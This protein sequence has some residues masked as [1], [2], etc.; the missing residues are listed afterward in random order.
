M[1]AFE[2][3]AIVIGAI[4]L[5]TV[6]LVIAVSNLITNT[7][8]GE[9]L[10][11]QEPAIITRFKLNIS[12][13][14]GD[15]EV[16]ERTD[17]AAKKLEEL[18][19]ERVEMIAR[20]GVRL[21]GHWYPCDNPVRIILAVHGWRSRWS[22]DYSGISPF[23]HENG[24]SVLYVEQRGQNA[25]D[26]DT[27]GF[28]MVER[29][30]CLDWLNWLNE[31]K[32]SDLPVYLAGISMGAASVLMAS[33]MGLPDNVH[34][35]MADCG[36]TSPKAIWEHI[37]KDNL[38]VSYKIREKKIDRMCKKKIGYT[39][40]EYST[41]KA[42]ET[43]STPILFVHGS[44]DT[45]VPIEMTY[46]N[47]L[48]CKAPKKLLVVPGANHAVSYIIDKDSYQKAVREFWEEFD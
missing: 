48:A 22:I 18:V 46:Q 34:G 9:A 24:C 25:S 41:L 39:S 32:K 38:H 15:N 35:V 33:G 27:M 3:V 45:F 11:R 21:V 23:W 36:Y 37:A 28:G 17:E 13:S 12:G 10:D 31:N 30:D 44:G 29:F 43:N 2:I 4:A 40:D 26:G 16:Y 7:L 42:M 47:Y 6:V 5:I 8:V 20:D 19:T 14:S 1:G